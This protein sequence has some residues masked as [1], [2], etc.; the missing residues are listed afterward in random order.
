MPKLVVA[1]CAALVLSTAA[2]GPLFSPNVTTV[3]A[4]G[5]TA[6]LTVTAPTTPVKKGDARIPFDVTVAGVTNL[7]AFQFE[8]TYDS[9]VLEFV[10]AERGAEKGDFLGSTNRQ[11]QCNSPIS[12]AGVVRFTCVTLGATPNGPN[13]G[14]KLA[15][16]YLNARGSGTTEVT[17]GR[18]KL[19]AV[20]D[21]NAAPT[22]PEAAPEIA[23]TTQNTSVK[24][25]GGGGGFNWLLWGPIIAVVVIAVLG[26]A[27]VAQRM[28]AK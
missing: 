28:R 13:G 5:A 3:R 18:V 7:A 1:A 23:A 16:I 12:D 9:N 20:G 21:P 15:T 8:L 24:V 2:V 10:D 17:L 11:V 27:V 22:A 19:I 26:A 6:T 14:G 4:Q 25:E